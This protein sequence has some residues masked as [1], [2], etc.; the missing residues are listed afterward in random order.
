MA[1]L[2]PISE[3][4]RS[5]QRE[6]FRLD[7]DTTDRIRHMKPRLMRYAE[8]ALEGVFD[9]LVANPEVAHYF[10]ISENITYLRAGM[11]AHCDRLFA[12][13]FDDLIR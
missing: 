5:I 3:E 8:R 2:N 10:E 12:C 6:F 13:R 1:R 4:H 7:E 9:H 11:L